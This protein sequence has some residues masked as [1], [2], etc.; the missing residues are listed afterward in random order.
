MA[1]DMRPVPGDLGAAIVT[2]AVPHDIEA[3][4]SSDPALATEWRHALR[5][6]LGPLM[7]AGAHITAFDTRSGY[8]VTRKENS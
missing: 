2:L 5:A 6:A 7:A 3:M 4:R 8:A 1:A